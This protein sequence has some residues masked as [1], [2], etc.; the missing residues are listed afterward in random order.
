MH[1]DLDALVLSS[2]DSTSLVTIP[3]GGTWIL[4]PNPRRLAIVIQ[5]PLTAQLQVRLGVQGT[6]GGFISITPGDLPLALALH[7][8]GDIIRREISVTGTAAD[9]FLF[10]ETMCP[11]G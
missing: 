1:K 9:T 11:C 10:S 3:A 7:D 2:I 8:V 5:P 4:P 6:D